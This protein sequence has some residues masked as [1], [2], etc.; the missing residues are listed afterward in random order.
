MRKGGRVALNRKTSPFFSANE[1][2]L[3][4]YGKW[5][6]TLSE[7]ETFALNMALGKLRLASY[8]VDY[9]GN[10]CTLVVKRNDPK[11]R[12]SL[13]EGGKGQVKIAISITAGLADYSK[14]LGVEELADVGDVP[15]GVFGAAEKKLSATLQTIYEKARNVDC[16][17]FG[18]Q[19]RL[20]K[21]KQRKYHRFKD[22][23]LDNISLVTD[24]SFRNV[25]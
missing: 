2:A 5:K 6:E 12:L 16:D 13:G 15:D 7:E 9:R 8:S 18:L 24:I 22:V 11:I 14:A 21:Y 20:I 3:F 4:V 25:R 17:V 23:L 1:T 19:E 10:T